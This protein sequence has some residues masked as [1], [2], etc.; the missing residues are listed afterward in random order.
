[1][2]EAVLKLE[3]D[4][5]IFSLCYDP[6]AEN[7]RVGDMAESDLTH[8]L[9]PS[10]KYATGEDESLM[11]ERL[12]QVAK[13]LG[14]STDRTDMELIEAFLNSKNKRIGKYIQIMPLYVYDH[15]GVTYSTSP[16]SCR[17]DSGQV[18][19]VFTTRYDFAQWRDCTFNEEEA[20]KVIKSEVEYWDYY[21]TGQAYQ[22]MLEEKTVDED[23]AVKTE[24]LDVMCGFIGDYRV[25]ARDIIDDYIHEYPDIVALKNKI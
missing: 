18:G 4:K 14:F 24:L 9:I 8:F 16:F 22:Y 5:H 15:S 20:M 19:W 21:A 25:L 7:P 12:H 23:G 11:T 13:A 3:S 6:Y 1:M 2:T 17:W 10:R